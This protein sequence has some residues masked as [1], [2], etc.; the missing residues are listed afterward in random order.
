MEPIEYLKLQAKN[1]HKDFKTQTISY[2]PKLRRNVYGYDPKFFKFDLL[3]DDFSINEEKFTLMNAQHIIAKLCGLDKWTELSTASPAKIELSVLLYTN[4]DRLEVR[5]WDQYVLD[6]ETSNNVKLEDEFKLKIFKEGFLQWQED[7]YYE[8][9]RLSKDDDDQIEWDR[10]DSATSTAAV[11]I[12]SLPLDEEAREKFITAANESFERVV[13]RIE[14]ENP[15]LIRSLWDA[16]KFIDEEIL[17]PDKLPID[18]EYALSL[19]DA[20]MFGYVRELAVEADEQAEQ[21]K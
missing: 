3:V 15:E 20:F 21:F 4:M 18:R 9:Y 2:D 7:V 13:E 11:K 17:T 8:D 5:D 19:V 14:L 6:I 10:E 12:S 16:E 1:L